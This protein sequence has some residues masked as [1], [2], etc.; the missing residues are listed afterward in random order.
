MSAS[1]ITKR[2]IFNLL[3]IIF[4]I[5]IILFFL[6]LVLLYIPPIQNWAVGHVNKYASDKIGMEISVGHVYLAFPL[7]LAVDEA[8]VL[9]KNDSIPQLKDTVADIKKTIVDI[10]FLP[11]FS[12][13]VNID[14]LNIKSIIFNTTK[15][16]PSARVKGS[17][18]NLVLNSHGIDFKRKHVLINNILLDGAKLDVQLNDTAKSNTAK[19]K[20]YWNIQFQ[21]LELKNTK[22][23][24]HMPNDT[25]D[26]GIKVS[27]A[28]SINGYIDLFKTLY[29]IEKTDANFDYITYDNKFEPWV[30]GFDNN[31]LEFRNIHIGIDSL[32][33][34]DP[35][36]YLKI[37]TGGFKW[38]SGFQLTNI[39]GKLKM[40]ARTVSIPSLYI[41]TKNSSL[42]ASGKMGLNAFD[43]LKPGKFTFKIKGSLGKSDVMLFASGIPEKTKAQWPHYPLSVDLAMSGN[44]KQLMINS[45]EAELPTAFKLNAKGKVL[46]VMTTDN[47]FAD[48]DIDA[49]LYNINFAI[50]P[51]ITPEI[52][53]LVRIPSGIKVKGGVIANG[54]L[55]NADMKMYLGR[56]WVSVDGSFNINKMAYDAK[57]TA[58]SF[59]IN[60]IIPNF[61]LTPFTGT[62]NVKG[63]G[64]DIFSKSMYVDATARI[65]RF[66]YKDIDLSNTKAIANIRNGVVYT[67]INCSNKLLNGEISLNALMSKKDLKAT[68]V[69]ALNKAD[70]YGMKLTKSP[71]MTSLCAHVDVESD[72]KE[73]Y[74]MQGFIS[75]V[76]IIDSASTFRANE[77]NIDILTRTDSTWAKIYSGDLMLDMAAG[78][79]YKKLMKLSDEFS[80]ELT[81]QIDRKYISQDS[82]KQVLPYGHLSFHSG[83]Q[84]FVR[85][86]AQKLG[87]QY[88]EINSDF[89]LSPITG[90]NGYAQLDSVY[91]NDMQLDKIRFEITT[92]E[93][94][95]KYKGQIKNNK[96]NPQYTFNALFDGSLFETGS[97]VN[98]AL[99]DDKDRLGL[100]MGVKAMLEPRGIRVMLSE[101]NIV[102]GYRKFRAN[103]DNYIYL[104]DNNRISASMQLKAEDN[105]GLQL[106][107]NDENIDALQ[108]LTIGVHNLDLSS[109][110]GIIPYFPDVKG[111]MNGDF[112]YIKT[113]KETSVSS[114]LGVNGM[115]YN[116]Y[117]MGD[118]SSEFVYMPLE[119]GGHYV[120]GI[121]M[122]NGND[123]GTI[124]GKYT[125][126]GKQGILDAD[127]DLEKLPLNLV[128]GFVPDQIVGLQGYGD[129]KLKIKGPL[130][131]MQ[132][133]GEVNLD[134]AYLVSVPYGIEMRFDNRPVYIKDSKLILEDFNM[135]S[136]AQQPL[137]INGDIDFSDF[138]KMNAN[139]RM[140]ARNFLIIDSKENRKS[141]VFGRAYVNFDASLK[142]PLSALRVNGNLDVLGSTDMTYIMRDTPLTTDNKLDELVKFTDFSATK[143]VEVY[144]PPIEGLYMNL[145]IS[146]DQGARVFCAL[147]STKSNYLDMIGGGELRMIYSQDELRLIGRY[148]VSSG[149]M[150]YS[151]PIIPLKT[152]NIQEGS[153]VEFTGDVINPTLN[154]TATETMKTN[155]SIAGSTRTVLFNCGVVVTQT[156]N[157]MGLTFII[158]APEDMSI[159]SELQAMSKE[160][161]GKLAVTMLTTGMY[162]AENNLSSFSM[163]DALNSF[164]QSEINNISGNAL[165]TL[166]LSIG[167]DNTTDA[168]G[169][170]HTDYTF[171][172]A[173][174]FWNNRVRV[175]VGG[176]V[177]SS[178]ASAENLFDNVALEY[179]LSQNSN[180]NLRLFYDRATYDFLE[181]YVGQYGVGIIW[182]KKLQSLSELFKW[183]K[184]QVTEF[185]VS[186]IKTKRDSIN[187]TNK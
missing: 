34:N 161:R 51:F 12:G 175:V 101:P 40:D 181:G 157:N 125:S 81:R 8:K 28:K 123:I 4:L 165:R 24:V 11:L 70:F 39:F 149:E 119:D 31:H 10:Q 57:I 107:S 130:S 94:G 47:L 140:K 69:F 73:L 145:N 183:N 166:D 42:S 27:H 170:L 98:L 104:A 187:I 53:K 44:L 68:L 185:P 117:R 50:N 63:N 52:K 65:Y 13:K 182:K 177:S 126:Q 129:G 138:N 156:L 131:A 133:N 64:T 114:S 18:D 43:N 128:N 35:N 85:E 144:R 33:Y 146:V 1:I 60:K 87:Y 167:L 151:L 178:Q 75:D 92:D 118:L 96:N 121:L 72:L 164:L 186:A 147:N 100:K 16:I 23:A 67:D 103:E 58:N 88:K 14:E 29:T 59:A 49:T 143:S 2:K 90:I 17:A 139:M 112:H 163:N 5:P 171:K 74:K 66:M 37:R 78:G 7:D 173:K 116:G 150:K 141:E 86:Y 3:G 109:I 61:S 102:L 110:T 172:F 48:L 55:Y 76:I 136:R 174:R 135:Y 155:V 95:F 9:Q 184:T 79:G 99:Y 32:K 106:F 169:T 180:T 45:L 142:G 168:A 113:E 179:R 38:K 19:S 80:R 89:T 36:L 30:K 127:I 153:Y 124:K 91:A 41:K 71:L 21:N 154:I 20:N 77:M 159:N 148:T 105:T 120:D 122:H 132:I 111:I 137:V 15:F 93:S 152:F 97:N 6:L 54:P 46:N 84:N 26:I 176:K 25:L 115:I 134:S 160:E 62:I 22:L 162:L 83:K 82:L 158:S 108:D 56:G